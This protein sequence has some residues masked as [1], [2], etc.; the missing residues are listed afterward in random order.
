VTRQPDCRR[1]FILPAL[2]LLAV[3]LLF[4]LRPARSPYLDSL[5]QGDGHA[6]RA[7]RTAAVAAYVEAAQVRPRDPAPYLR[8]TRLYL[9][10][11]R[12]EDAMVA[13][14]EAEQRGGGEVELERLWVAIHVARGDRPAVVEHARRLLELAPGDSSARHTLARAYLDLH[15]W[16]AGRAEFEAL[17]TVDPDDGLAHERLGALLA[18]ADPAGIQHL[19][20]A[21]TDLAER[22]L[23]ALAA[24]GVAD[25]PAYAGALLG[26]ALFEEGEWALAARQFERALLENPDYP[27]AH[28]YLGYALDRMGLPGEA[29][30]YLLRAVALAPDSA[31]AHT[32]LGLHY[33]RL[34]DLSAARQE[35]ETAYDLDPANPATCVEIGQTWAAEGRYVAAEIWLREAVA[36]QPD[37]AALWEI[38]ARF[39]LDHEIDAGRRG[40]EAAETLVELAPDDARAHDLRGWAAFQAGDTDAA[41]ESLTQA[42]LLDPALPSAHYHLGW[43]W[44]AQG[45]RQ[46]AREALTRALDLDTGGALTPLV[47]RAMAEMP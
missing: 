9:D 36:L 41:R 13:L 35:F 31:A 47:E 44:V 38:L 39:Y 16:D 8:L 2:A 14:V 34:G 33:E 12:P 23:A 27:D 5:R 18:G 19:F 4:I 10:W 28:A 17:L 6:A 32:F 29:R 26:Q 15:E 45:D 42:L 46:R 21:E 7:E 22:L 24:P 43:L 25:D 20:A 30:P 40:T 1:L 11:G 3:A 37:D